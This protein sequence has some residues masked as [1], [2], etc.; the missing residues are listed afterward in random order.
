MKK[1][2][3]II[4]NEDFSN[5]IMHFLIDSLGATPKFHHEF[6]A[7]NIS[8]IWQLLFSIISSPWSNLFS[9]GSTEVSSHEFCGCGIE[10]GDDC[11][12]RARLQVDQGI[13]LRSENVLVVSHGNHGGTHDLAH[14][15]FSCVLYFVRPADFHPKEESARTA[16]SF[17]RGM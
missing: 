16:T 7:G 14:L 1:V 10:L 13:H 12:F 3:D 2:S 15:P 5:G 6:E 8:N 4:R 9:R 11:F 17:A